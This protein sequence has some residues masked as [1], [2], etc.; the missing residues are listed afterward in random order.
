[1]KRLRELD[2]L[3]GVAILLVLFRHQNIFPFLAKMGWI[4]VDLFFVLSGFL[5]SG[6]L[7]KEYLKFGDIQPKRFLIRRGFKIYPIYFLFYIPYLI[8]IL[9][10]GKFKLIPFLADM[11]FLQNYIVGLGYAYSASWS[12]S[13]EEHFYFGFSFL[14]WL[15]L[16][17]NKISLKKREGNTVGSN[18]FLVFIILTMILCLGF[19]FLSNMIFPLQ[20]SRNYSMTHLRI[21][22]LLAGVLISWFYY[23]RAD[24]LRKIFQSYKPLFFLVAF[25]GLIWTPF[26]EPVVSFFAYTAGFTLV[27]ISFGILL[28]FFLLE[29]DINHT[30]NKIFSAFVVN[31]VSKIGYCSYSIYIIYSFISYEV[32]NIISSYNLNHNVYADFFIS[33]ALSV[34]TGM[35]MTYYIESYFLKIRDKYYPGRA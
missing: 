12:L 29:K 17:Y 18:S 5:I 13:V 1:L 31:V 22:S 23:F 21:D 11:T 2:F 9:N 32:G 30:L 26:I 25:S 4:G 6:L 24:Y 8:L 28:L 27:Y 33:A 14:L 7:F 10:D 15:G 3:R 20:L 35:L 19:R 16:K 34:I